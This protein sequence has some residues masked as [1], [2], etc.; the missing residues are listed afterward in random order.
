MSQRV[1]EVEAASLEEARSRAQSQL[2]SNA[3][4]FA[5]QI[6]SGGTPEIIEAM[7]ASVVEAYEKAERQLPRG[8]RIESKS[9]ERHPELAHI[10]LEADSE[11]AARSA[12]R[13]KKGQRLESISLRVP[14][15]AGFIGLWK[16][17]PMFQAKVL[18]EAVIKVRFCL[19]VKIRCEFGTAEDCAARG[20]E[21][22]RQGGSSRD[23]LA[24]APWDRHHCRTCHVGAAHEFV[25][26]HGTR[27]D[28]RCTFCGFVIRRV[29][30]PRC[31]D[32]TTQAI[33]RLDSGRSSEDVLNK[34]SVCERCTKLVSYWNQRNLGLFVNAENHASGSTP[35]RG[36]VSRSSTRALVALASLSRRAG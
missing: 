31:A 25:H 21:W 17:P 14:G 11:Q 1:I 33:V 35:V 27:D 28:E 8:A 19:P 13:L 23:Q 36:A 26:V 18:Q 32:T 16:R 9:V 2:D 15:R 24:A 10:E 5:E 7:G 34:A 20:H 6:V 29:K 30:C 22:E 4:V 3:F 12:V